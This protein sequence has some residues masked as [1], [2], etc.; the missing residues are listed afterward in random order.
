MESMKHKLVMTLLVLGLIAAAAAIWYLIAVMPD[1][2]G[3][4]GTLVRSL[5]GIERMVS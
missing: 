3:K 5:P 1:G 4:E 2:G